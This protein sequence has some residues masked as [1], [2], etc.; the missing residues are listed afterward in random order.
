MLLEGR[1]WQEKLKTGR[2][3]NKTDKM[4]AKFTE[5]HQGQEDAQEVTARV[6]YRMW[7]RDRR[8]RE[9]NAEGKREGRRHEET[10]VNEV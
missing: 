8:N 3:R 7:G 1:R 10:S 6:I 2:E 5:G 9:I 4:K